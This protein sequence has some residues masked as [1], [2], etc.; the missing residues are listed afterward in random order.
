[1]KGMAVWREEVK[2]RKVTIRLL[3][4]I[5]I[6]FNIFPLPKLPSSH[7]TFPT[8]AVYDTVKVLSFY[9]S[10]DELPISTL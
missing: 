6:I 5:V 3:P 1:V 10:V 9:G 7:T 4:L 2:N 8:K